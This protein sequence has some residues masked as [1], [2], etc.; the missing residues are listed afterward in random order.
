[1]VKQNSI[2]KIEQMADKLK[3]IAALEWLI[4][5]ECMSYVGC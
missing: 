2:L 4:Q 5:C 3:S 1:M